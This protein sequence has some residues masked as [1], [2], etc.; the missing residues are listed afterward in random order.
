M[1]ELDVLIVGPS[2]RDTGGIARYIAEQSTHLSGSVAITRYDISTPEGSGLTWFLYSILLSVVDMLQF[3]LQ[4]RPDVVHVH[5]SHM[6]SFLRIVFYVLVAKYLWQ[7][8]VVLHVHGSSFD[9]FVMTD[10]VVLQFVQSVVFDASDRIVVLSEYWKDVLGLAVSKSKLVV[11]P[12]AVDP[13]EYDPSFETQTPRVTFVSNH[14]ERKG[15]VE[16]VDA[17]DE[18]KQNGAPPFDVSI[19][20]SGPL[21]EHAETL[22]ESHDEVTYLGYVSESDKRELLDG[23]NIY[24]LPTYAEGLPIALLEGMAGGNA[25]VTTDVG[26]IPE[27]IDETN[28][29]IV[30]P[31]NPDELATALDELLNDPG[32]TTEMAARNHELVEEQYSWTRSTKQLVDIYQSVTS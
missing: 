13:S 26:S 21:A 6:F 15:I 28:G 30:S 17:V 25:V 10:S 8:P 7:R 2:D 11:V 12:N 5:T 23:S 18:L 1:S 9:E 29:V 32:R 4:R 24:V 31:G 20:G 3:P 14:V 16:F 27:V 19:A 22:A